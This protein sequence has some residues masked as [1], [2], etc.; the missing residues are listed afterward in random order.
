MPARTSRGVIDSLRLLAGSSDRRPL[1]PE[2]PMRSM[3]FGMAGRYAARSRRP[4][5]LDAD[6]AGLHRHHCRPWSPWPRRH[7]RERALAPGHPQAQGLRML[8]AASAAQ[9]VVSVLTSSPGT[10]KMGPRKKASDVLYRPGRGLAKP[11]IAE[12]AHRKASCQRWQAVFA[13]EPDGFA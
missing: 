9:S 2:L 5:Y 12:R 11:R 10:G 3:P 6:S 1:E 4:V 13:T 8:Q 7:H